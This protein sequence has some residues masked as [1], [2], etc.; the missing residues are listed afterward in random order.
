MNEHDL[1]RE[2]ERTNE[3][4]STTTESSSGL[5]TFVN[6]PFVNNLS[7]V[8]RA[9]QQD[10]SVDLGIDADLGAE[11]TETVEA[12][13]E[14]DID[15]E[16][17][18]DPTADL[19]SSEETE[20]EMSRLAARM[21]EQEA[22]IVADLEALADQEQKAAAERLAREIAEDQALEKQL[23]EEAERAAETD[24]ELLAALPKAPVADGQGNLDLSEL[25]SCIETLLFMMDRPCSNKR[26]QELL[27]PEMD[28][29]LFDQAIAHLQA[30]YA[31]VHHGFELVAVGGGFQ[32][33]TKP[34]RAA[35]A[36]KL[37]KVQ[38]QRLSTGAMET[39]AIIAYKQPALKEDVD[40]IRGVDSSHFI[41]GLLDKKLIRIAGRSEMVGRPMLYA[42][43]PEFLEL[44]GLA[45]LEAL[46]SLRELEQM[47]PQSQTKSPEDE[48]P[49]VKEM[50][51]LVGEMKAD[52]SVS[53][54]YDPREDEKFLQEIREKVQAIPTSSPYLEA[55]KEAEKRAKLVAEGKM[56]PEE[57]AALDAA[58]RELL[59]PQA[60][61][62]SDTPAEAPAQGDLLAAVVEE[63]ALA[64]ALAEAPVSPSP[65]ESL[66]VGLSPEV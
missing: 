62:A 10:D 55:Q 57:A 48:D 35:L 34:G 40:K 61:V 65:T 25:E 6:A 20:A 37:A 59:L 30:R 31:A 29:T 36:K 51:R 3:S 66:D 58:A 42:T 38:T 14:D 28:L 19:P 24:P 32:F 11:W 33:R 23:K 60:S 15:D 17:E 12:D 9:Q 18:A 13:I 47:V 8:T 43:T 16:D 27:G 44:F 46:P 21:A 1:P 64:E 41:R 39:L 7:D 54:L 52:G 56:T 5:V 63:S 45:G 50:R 4:E 49:R 2:D 53:L 26:L 22:E